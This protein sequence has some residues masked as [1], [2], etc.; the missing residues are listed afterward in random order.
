MPTEATSVEIPEAF[1]FLLDPPHGD[2]RFRAAYGGRGS[3]KSHSFATALVAKAANQPLRIGCYREIQKSIR[4]SSKRLIDDKIAA[5]GLQSFFTSTDVEIR[6]LNGSLFLFNGLRTNI[7][8]VRSTEGLDIAWVS[9]AHSVAQ[10]SWD[11][12]IPTVRKPGSEIWTEWNPDL[13]TDPVDAMFRTGST[14]PRTI[15]RQVNYEDN[16]WFPP[17]L[18]ELA[19]YDRRRDFDKYQHIWLGEYR[20]NSQARVF[21]N[22]TVEAFD[23]PSDVAF[24][25]GADWGFSIDPTVLI[26]CYIDGR[27]LYIDH[28]AYMLGCEIDQTP[29]LFDHVPG[30]RRWLITADSARPETISYMQRQGFK[31]MPALKGARSL[32]EGV[33]FLK[34]FDIIVHPRCTKTLDELN[35]YSYKIDDL[36]GEPIPVLEDKNNH[37]IDA[38]RYA[39]EGARRAGKGKTIT[40]RAHV[41]AVATSWMAA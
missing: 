21:N 32:E 35:H 3:G 23:T 11:V 12:L 28:E 40:V 2:V 17:E 14:P 19:E 13:P 41:P 38:L 5:L 31:I 39:C 7:D 4:D 16:P 25:F 36:T 8:A 20:R 37:L 29:E 18:H 27:K 15:V 9:E 34:T 30:A 10:R 33:E 26:R 1:G 24:R 22:W 6:G